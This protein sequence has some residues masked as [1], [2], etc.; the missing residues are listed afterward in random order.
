MV[1]DPGIEKMKQKI[2]RSRRGEDSELPAFVSEAFA[3]E[4]SQVHGYPVFRLIPERAVGNIFYL[5][6][7]NYTDAIKKNQWQYIISLCNLTGMAVTVPLYPLAPEHDCEEVF[8]FIIPAYQDFCKHREAGPI[9]MVGAGTGAGI[10]LSMLLQIWKEGL[11]DPDKVVFLSPVM[12]TEF[13]DPT[14]EKSLK[15]SMGEEAFERKKQFLN[16]YWVRNFAGRMEFT[17]PVYEDMHD[18]SSDILVA[19]GTNDP[20]N[21]YA[22]FLSAK[23]QDTGNPL[24]FFEY[25]EVNSDFYLQEGRKETRHLMKILHDV[26]LDTDEMILH[27]YYEEV[28]RR[29]DWSKYFPEVFRD[30]H[31]VRYVS[32]HPRQTS[33]EKKGRSMM[34]LL[35][36]SVFRTL[37]DSVKLFLDEYPN[38]T[39]VYVGCGLDTM[40]ERVDNG[41]VLWYNLDSP[42]RMAVRTMYTGLGNREKRIQRSVHDYRW[43]SE[44]SV[45]MDK[46]LLFVVRDIFSYMKWKEVKEFLDLLYQEFRGCN[47]LF[48]MAKPWTKFRLNRR[49][50][51]KSAEYRKRHLSM[52]DPRQDLET[53]S[54]IYSVISVQSSLDHVKPKK[55]WKTGL[56]MALWRA[57]R[58]ESW[59]VVH[60]RLGYERYK[61]FEDLS[62]YEL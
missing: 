31:A 7:S 20:W 9:V 11:A 33:V 47:V 51:D 6:Q 34:N 55:D 41:R 39:V 28:W 14:L 13:F 15:N 26:L 36:A 56:R 1:H 23:V 48:D 42:G 53:M 43:L 27:R 52:R 2:L 32:G 25:R 60:V 16:Q 29:A 35:Q 54:P 12:D 58:A 40:L 19:S 18:I 3:V 46:G 45:E 4:R 49:K 59:K 62:G 21:V 30:E 10:G 5:Y 37:D 8:D 50:T 57:Q 22:R 38:G 17:A 44:L 24:K 61:T